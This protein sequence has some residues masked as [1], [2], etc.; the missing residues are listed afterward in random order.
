MWREEREEKEKE[1]EEEEERTRTR[2]REEKEK[3]PTLR[4]FADW[5][6]GGALLQCSARPFTTLPLPSHPACVESEDQPE[7]KA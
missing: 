4:V 5:L 1:E 3:N 2:R 7:V 6:R